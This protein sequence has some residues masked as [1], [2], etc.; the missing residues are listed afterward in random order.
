M[1][2]AWVVFDGRVTDTSDAADVEIEFNS[3][4]TDAM[5]FEI[6]AGQQGYNWSN[7]RR[8][9]CASGGSSTGKPARLGLGASPEYPQV[10]VI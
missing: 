5:C 7:A 10:S 9:S 2:S 6:R 8:R 4:L 3:V 1:V